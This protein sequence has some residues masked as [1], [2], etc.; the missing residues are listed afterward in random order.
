MDF[1]IISALSSNPDITKAAI[2]GI[3]TSLGKVFGESGLKLLGQGCD[4]FLDTAGELTQ[5]GKELL[6]PIARKYIENYTDRH[7][8]LRV[9]GMGKPVS[10]ESIYTWVNFAP[11]FVQTFQTVNAQEEAF[12][13]RAFS[14]KEHRSGME[15]VNQEQY[16]MVLGAPG[17]G[18]TTFLRKVGLE[19]LKQ[20]QGEYHHSCIPVLL[21][22]RKYR[23]DKATGINLREKIAEE[24]QN[25]GLPEYQGC[26]ERLLEQGKLLILFDGLD[27]VPTELLGQMTG[28]IKDLVD[29]YSKNRFI[30]SCRIAAYRSF[31]NFS[32][33]TDVAIA[34]FDEQQIQCFIESWFKSHDR[35]E[36]GNECQIRLNSD[37][38]KATRELAQTPL[39]LT[40]ICI[41]FL[42]RGE[43]PTKK[44]TLYDKALSTLLEEWDTSKQ[45]VRQQHYKGLNSQGKEIM[46]AEIAYSS[47]TGNKLFFLQ[48][49]ISQQIEQILKE[50]LSR[51]QQINGRDVLRALEEQHGL[52][53]NRYE[54][55]YSFSDLS[56]QEFLTAKHIV[57]NQLNLQDLVDQHLFD[58]RWRRIFLFL[59][60]LRKADD[61]LVAIDHRLQAYISTPN[62]QSLLD[63]ANQATDINSKDISPLW[64]KV[65]AIANVYGIACNN[66]SLDTYVYTDPNA[67]ISP[68]VYTQD[69]S[70]AIEKIDAYARISKELQIYKDINLDSLI[71]NLANL[72][73]QMVKID[74]LNEPHRTTAK[75]LVEILLPAFNLSPEM[76]NISRN[77]LDSLN[78]YIYANWLLI[79]CEQSAVRRT[80]E[81]WNRIE[82]GDRAENLELLIDSY[83]QALQL[84]PQTIYP[85]DWIT[86]QNSLGQAYQNRIL[87]NRSE[88]IEQSID[89]YQQALQ[90]LNPETFPKDWAATQNNLGKAYRSR[91]LGDKSEN[92]E[93]SITYHQQALRVLNPETFPQSWAVTQNNLGEAYRSRILGDK[94]ENLEQ[95]IEHYQQALQVLNPGSSPQDWAMTQN[96][97]GEVYIMR[98]QLFG[99][100]KH[101][102]AIELLEELT[103][104]FL[105]NYHWRNASSSYTLWAKAL[106]GSAAV[107]PI[108]RAI[109]LDWQY[110]PDLID[111]DI[112]EL[113]AILP[114]L[115]WQPSDLPKAWQSIFHSTIEPELL[116]KVYLNIGLIGR[117]EGRWQMAIDYFSAAWQIYLNSDNLQNF[118]EINYQLANTHHLMS[119]FSKAGMYYRDARRLFQSLD[120][121]RRVAFCDHALGRLLFQIG[122]VAQSIRTFEQAIFIY[123]KLP[124][125]QRDEIIISQIEDAQN[126]LQEI[127]EIYPNIS[128]AVGA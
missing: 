83:Q 58:S 79:E 99:I 61:L 100:H 74:Q 75:K 90:V 16:L 85:T 120:N 96:N 82:V 57:D 108:L 7:G 113:A 59:S 117:S 97:L 89:C 101:N 121:Q 114:R 21:E 14:E 70:C 73:S 103:T 25:C 28:A 38:H 15:V 128:T 111:T 78:D 41:L 8:Q 118:A 122:D 93:Q 5:Q 72:Q 110:N 106:S 6:A 48:E 88:N 2:T 81:I 4:K 13:N 91:I 17:M 50:M 126:Y 36:W 60:G 39:L 92:L 119:N 127:N 102:Q 94:S 62:L 123:R 37:D 80:P 51:E 26:T 84:H 19:A 24:F 67:Y 3:V 12:R 23:W 64:K 116:A 115:N 66:V 44:A 9:L 10:L 98:L 65:L 107:T 54:D 46:L 69:I 11:V 95:S 40:L 1:G 30:A 18:K 20:N 52:L 124:Y 105:Q 76:V 49:E 109:N 34:D 33:F 31:Q 77:E 47:F 29:R 53:V 22:L 68:N 56:I 27:E 35:S 32:R 63:W 86:L 112:S 87:G 42:K 104:F 45:I 55:V 71:N 43:F 125:D